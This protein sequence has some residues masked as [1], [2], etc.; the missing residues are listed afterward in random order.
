MNTQINRL[1]T[2]SRRFTLCKYI[3]YFNGFSQNYYMAYAIA[4]YNKATIK[5][6]PFPYR[7]TS[8]TKRKRKPFDLRFCFLLCEKFVDCGNQFVI[9][10][11]IA[12]DRF[13]SVR[14]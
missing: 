13:R 6:T 4:D 8:I 2:F 12:R 1:D 11:I 9:A 7:N 5:L 14:R 3:K 10:R